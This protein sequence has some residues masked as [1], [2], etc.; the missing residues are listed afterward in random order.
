M[1]AVF[2]RRKRRTGLG[3]LKRR[4]GLSSVTLLAAVVFGAVAAKAETVTVAIDDARILRLPERVATVVIGNPLIADATLQRGG[5]LVV[6]GKGYGAT[7]LMALDRDGQVVLSKTV[8]VQG[9]QQRNLVVVYRGADR[10]SY[11]CTPGCEPRITLG[12]ANAYFASTLG[13]TVTRNG[14]ARGRGF[15]KL[16]TCNLLLIQSK[17]SRVSVWPDND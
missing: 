7:N 4:L 14:N 10:Q 2:G 11:S 15:K 13:Q 12:D 5:V 17:R 9:P 6:T 3:R 8:R 16:T 1:S